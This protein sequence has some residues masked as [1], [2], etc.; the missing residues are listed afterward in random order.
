[1]LFIVSLDVDESR[2][3]FVWLLVPLDMVPLDI[4]PLVEAPWFDIPVEPVAPEVVAL[5]VVD[6]GVGLAFGV[7]GIVEEGFAAL[8]P[9]FA[10][11]V[12]GAPPAL[13][14]TARLAPRASEAA[15]AS[16]R[17]GDSFLMIM[18]P[19]ARSRK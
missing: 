6:E 5:D 10:V 15:A 1:M 12:P 16:V 8:G 2:F 18:V 4:D 13:C 14:A 17:M 11:P 7:A 9:A 19:V 3:M